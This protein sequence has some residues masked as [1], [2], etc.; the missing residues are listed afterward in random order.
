MGYASLAYFD[1]LLPQDVDFIEVLRGAEASYYGMN[2][3]NGVVSV[4]IRKGPLITEGQK[5]N[6]KIFTPV[7]YHVTPQFFMPDYSNPNIKN[8]KLPDLRTTVYWNGNLTTNLK[9]KAFENFYTAD[10]ATNYTVVVTGLTTKGDII[11][12]RFLLSRN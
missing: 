8:S 9:G 1:D 7:T 5:S 10:N 11:Y 4:N 2:G 3:A 6:F 12:K